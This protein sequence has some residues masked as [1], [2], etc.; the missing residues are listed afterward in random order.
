[1]MSKGQ[2][3]VPGRC[4]D[5]I[6]ELYSSVGIILPSISWDGGSAESLLKKFRGLYEYVQHGRT[7][8]VV[9]WFD[10]ME[11]LHHLAMIVGDR[12]V[13]V[14]LCGLARYK[15]DQVMNTNARIMRYVGPGCQ[16]FQ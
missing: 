14:E 4:Y 10:A 1:M 12:I 16:V 15:P 6:V 9:L 7:G 3:W 5:L 2:R 11:C 13:G 8:D